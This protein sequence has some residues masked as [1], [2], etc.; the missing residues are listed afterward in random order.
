MTRKTRSVAL[1]VALAAVA[2]T[3]VLTASA[4][5]FTFTTYFTNWRV[6]GSLTDKKLNQVIVFPQGT[7]NGEAEIELNTL[8]GALFGTTEIPTFETTIK[9]FGLPAN[10]QVTFQ[11]VGLVEGSIKPSSGCTTEGAC[12]DLSVPTKVNLI[13]KNLKILG[14][15]IPE[16]CETTEPGLL[17]LNEPLT[18]SEFISVGSHFTG[19]TKIAP[20]KC[21]GLFG[22]LNGPLLTAVMSGPENAYAINISPPA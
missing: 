16:T 22:L 4:S 10:V 3:F 14:L 5:A 8:S 1:V 21:N 2:A 15:T 6:T 13:L 20:I 12:I 7:F 18:I 11:Q 19:T 17:A 9:L